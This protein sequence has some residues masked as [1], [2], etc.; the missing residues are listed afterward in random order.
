[1]QIVVTMPVYEDWDSAIELCQ[2]LDLVLQKE[3]A[4]CANLLLVDDG[5]IASLAPSRIPFQPEAIERISVLTL[6]RNLGHQR[7]IAIGLAYIQQHLKGDAVVVMDADGEDRPE[8]LPKLVEAMKK[9][10]VPTAVFAE[11]GKRLE[12]TLFRALYQCYRI[13]HRVFIGRDIRFGNF[14]VLPWSYLESLV[15]F[16]E[17]WNHYAAAFLNSRLP[18]LRVRL[19]RGARLRG[20]SH[21][22]FVSLLIHGLSAVFANQEVVGTRL[23]VLILLAT[24]SFFIAIAVTV[25]VGLLLHLTIPG[26]AI[27]SMGLLLVLIGQALTAS[28]VLVFSIMMNRSHLG[29]LP[30]RDYSFFVRGEEVLFPQ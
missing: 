12:N 19:D 26:W 13:L 9:A 30:V 14:S 17:L 27:I 24:M 25:G 29:F 3:K 10:G 15:V 23:L 8:D 4:L 5:S 11:R 21:M 20:R 1:M 22:N 6:R 7:A 2:K 18:Y 16:P 28:F